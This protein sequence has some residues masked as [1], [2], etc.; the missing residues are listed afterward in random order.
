MIGSVRVSLDALRRNALALRDLIAPARAAFV[1]KA[2]AY[3]HGLVPVA[4][5]IEPVAQRICVYSLDEAI[6]LRDA[7]ITRQIFV[8]GPI[9]SRN[10]EEA[11][12]RNLEIA[13]W[14]TRSYLHA[15][16]NAAGKRHGRFP[17]HVKINTGASRL[18][19]EPRDAC[20]AIEDY[21][22]ISELELAGI[23]SHL[24]AAEELD[25]PFTAGQLERF[26]RVLQGV[27]PAL[28][29][30]GIRPMRHIAASAAAMLWP[31]TRLEMARIGIALYGLWPSLQTRIAMNGAKF[32]LEPAL[33]FTSQL[34]AV[35]PVEAGT[36][37][38]YGCTYHAPKSTRV[39]VVPLGYADGIPR[40][41]SNRGAF[42]AGGALCPIVGRVCMNMTMI[43]LQ[44]APQVKPGDP[45]TLIGTQGTASVTADDWAGWAETINYEIVARLPENLARVFEETATKQTGAAL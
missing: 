12:A 44:A 20:D 35:R 5:A 11:F 29:A 8:M 43:D 39:G 24:A 19:L 32:E 21:A 10:L 14:D 13:L 30:K 17:V 31:Q 9:E 22:R 40:L 38:G 37:I 2:N 36:P 18:G 4:R 33:S 45:V 41:L 27:A 15:V 25:S 23:F 16:A 1:V 42:I 3:G 7:G 28:E 6:V 26:E 34:A